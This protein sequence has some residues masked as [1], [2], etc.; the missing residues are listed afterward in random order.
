MTNPVPKKT[1]IQANI[2]GFGGDPATVLTTY[3]QEFDAAYVSK[4]ARSFSEQKLEGVDVLIT[5]V[6]GANAD[7]MFQESDIKESIA[8]YFF[9]RKRPSKTKGVFGM[10]YLEDFPSMAHPDAYIEQDGMDASGWQYRIQS[11]KCS[12]MAVLAT[13]HYL[14]KQGSIDRALGFCDTMQALMSG[15]GVTI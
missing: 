12:A 7:S 6:A 10:N 2:V 5:N 8:D 14:K 13:A 3:I 11:I 9:L 15:R 4:V 1:V